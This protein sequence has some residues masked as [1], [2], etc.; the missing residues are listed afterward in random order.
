MKHQI[1]TTN[2]SS[3]FIPHPRSGQSYRYMLDYALCVVVGDLV[4]QS[5]GQTEAVL[6]IRGALDR[7]IRESGRVA[8]LQDDPLDLPHL[9]ER[10]LRLYSD[11]VTTST[12][13]TLAYRRLQQACA[14]LDAEAASDR[15]TDPGGL[16]EP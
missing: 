13:L 5:T 8:L 10:T 3:E 11:L 15:D 16:L 12:R 2:E 9:A 6:A 4:R 7:L 14:A 1:R